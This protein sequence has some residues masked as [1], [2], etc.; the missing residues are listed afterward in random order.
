LFDLGRIEPKTSKKKKFDYNLLRIDYRCTSHNNEIA[1][2]I[3]YSSQEDQMTNTEQ[4]QFLSKIFDIKPP[5]SL[6]HLGSEQS[7]IN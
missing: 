6:S 3:I 7:G 4:F 5:S 1:T 2:I